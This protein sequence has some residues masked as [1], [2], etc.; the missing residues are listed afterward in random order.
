M[1]NFIQ[2]YWLL[3]LKLF[4]LMSSIIILVIGGYLYYAI[5][6]AE[7]KMNELKLAP[8]MTTTKPVKLESGSYVKKDH[9]QKYFLINR[10]KQ[11]FKNWLFKL[12][13]QEIVA[14]EGDS[15]AILKDFELP[16]ILEN[17]CQRFKCVQLRVSFEEI[18][19]SLW[20]GLLGVE[21]FRFLE[22]KGVD[23]I[24]ILR[25]IIVDIKAMKLVQ[26]GSTLTQQLVKNLFL[27]NE[28]KFERKLRE[29]IYAV[30]LERKLSK[31]QIITAY[32][33]EV[34]WGTHQGVYLKGIGAASNA[35]FG[36]K[37][38]ELTEY[39]A[40]ILIGLLKG[41]YF[42]HPRLHPERLVK[43]AQVVFNRLNSIGLIDQF[44]EQWNK[45]NW[46]AWFDQVKKDHVQSHLYSY[47][48]LKDENKDF[49]N[50]YEKFVFYEAVSAVKKLLKERFGDADMAVKNF[51]IST[52][53]ESDE[54]ENSFGFYS[55][56]ER[57][58][59][60]ALNEE[61]HQVG[62]ILKPIIYE[63]FIDMGRKLSDLVSTK[64]ITLKLK[65]GEWTP[66]DASKVKEEEVTLL[67]A[68]QKSKN[69][70]LIRTANDIGFEKLEERLIS[71][72]PNLLVPLG[73]YPAQLL[74]AIE[75]SMTDVANA[76]LKY[77]E[78][79]CLNV[80][81]EKYP[82]EESILY[83]LS[84]ASETTIS[85]VANKKIKQITMF[86]KTGTTNKGL[87]NWYVAFDGE[88]I[89]ITW[90]GVD[91][92]RSGEKIRL[93]GASSAYRIFQQFILFRGKRLAEVYCL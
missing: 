83:Y 3:I 30:Y 8:V 90:F 87:D 89:Y 11:S 6:Q 93:S 45:S 14:I 57:K 48:L 74:G 42:Y 66:K 20:K 44:T 85:R 47:Y 28:K 92:Q 9:L 68:L 5:S 41:P 82:Y 75:L 58:K 21:D 50:P 46:E 76:Y 43:R 67:R 61:A 40:A 38:M 27:S 88:Q 84:H 78:K 4:L 63:E 23:I 71:Y 62:S 16:P 33:N 54:C 70:P 59:D 2:K 77:I 49:W 80:K 39:E 51:S 60:V 18:P 55:K 22:H 56:I 91:A 34:F 1:R 15:I 26:G 17:S 52:K 13:E 24:S 86:G 7:L 36:K 72:F 69:I 10:E 32:F 35:Y 25:A 37:P 53:C 73:E 31:E 29:I 64:P 19:S 79:S 12:Q 81:E 65:S